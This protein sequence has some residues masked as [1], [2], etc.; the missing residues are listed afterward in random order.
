MADS[1]TLP[2]YCLLGA[3]GTGKGTQAKLLQENEGFLHISSGDIFR[4][5]VAKGD[6]NALK[7]KELME[8][9]ELIPDDTIRDMMAKQ[10]AEKLK[11]NQDAKGVILDGFPR[12]VGQAALLDELL[13]SVNLHFEGTINIEVPEEL[14]IERLLNR[15][16][17]DGSQRAD[18]N[19]EVIRERMR[20]WREKTQP[21]EDYYKQRGLLIN[22][23]GVGNIEEVYER[24]LKV[25]KKN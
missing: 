18:D 13:Q 22:V 12:T 15:K 20:V 21:L 19:E 4:E 8:K 10:L 16:A 6:P 2:T 14:L 11:E 24:L 25:F 23:D 3:P 7:V 17:E 9:G 5:A 1:N